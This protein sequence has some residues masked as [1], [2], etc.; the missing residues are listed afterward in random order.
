MATVNVVKM[1]SYIFSAFKMT[2]VVVNVVKIT[3]LVVLQGRN[4]PS[5]WGWGRGGAQRIFEPKK[6]FFCRYAS[7]EGVTSPI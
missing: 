3:V 7:F 2:V 6:G 1:E 5:S 4:L